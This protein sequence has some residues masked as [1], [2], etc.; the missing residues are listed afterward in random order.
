M[1]EQVAAAALEG[2]AANVWLVPLLPFLAFLVISLVTRPW[3]RVSAGVS[4]LALTGSLVVSA[5]VFLQRV[6]GGGPPM[7]HAWPW[8]TVA[9]GQPLGAIQVGLLVDNLSALMLLMVCFVGLCIQVYSTA[10]IQTEIGHFPTQGSASMSRFFGYLSLFCFSMLGLVLSHNLLQIYIFWELVGV[11][12]Y[13]L[14]G[15]WYFKHSAAE[16]CKKAFVVTRFGDLGF[17][18][19]ILMLGVALKGF[20][21]VGLSQQFSLGLPS[22]LTAGF[23]A[24]AAVLIFCGAVGK[25]AQFPLQVW[26]PDA[27]EGPTPVSALIHAATMVAAGVYLVARI[28]PVFHPAGH[29]G[30]AAMVVAWIGAATALMAATIAVV[31][32]DIKR[33]LAYS[34]ISQLGFMM[35]ALGVGAYTAGSFHLITHAFFKALLFLGSGAVIVACHSNDMWRMGGL[36]KHLPF[37][38][39][40]FL[41][42]CL[43][44]AGVPPL[45]GF[46]SKDEILGFVHSAPGG[47]AVYVV[48]TCSAFLTAFYVTRMY[49]IAFEGPYRGQEKA[50]EDLCGPVPPANLAAPYPTSQALDVEPEWTEEKAAA[51]AEPLPA[52]CLGAGMEH[53]PHGH[54]APHEVSPL[55]WGP[56]LVLAV[57]AVFLGFAGVPTAVGLGLPN[58][59]EGFIHLPGAGHAHEFSWSPMVTSTVVALAGIALAA[60]LFAGDAERGER[61]LRRLLGPLWPFL[62]QKWYMDHLWARLLAGTMYAGARAGAWFDAQV[63]DG[64]VFGLARFTR[65]CGGWMRDEHTGKVQH[66]AL[67][68]LLALVILAV[69]I[70]FMEPG[71]F[72]SR[73]FLIQM[74]E[75]GK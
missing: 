68:L 4:I 30:E 37:T 35:A 42:G 20:D 24:V 66:Y 49:F 28:F 67:L 25:S 50:P 40:A 10:Y 59:F 43:A 18:M 38:W 72:T 46:W 34:T 11:C 23:V 33:V 56:L 53:L 31:Q 60:F 74:M 5:Q 75:G 44:L 41:M 71:F 29:P 52:A 17:L 39:F 57:F 22:G 61:R 14:I 21:F 26:L 69:G 36:R 12:S 8:I 63:V 64:A 48:L 16:A 45:A 73:H 3:G 15:F 58:Y 62:Q 7:Q 6:T 13:L 55:M 27:M 65:T 51:S 54:H 47:M 70:G 1:H 9:P 19:G 2:A 32:N